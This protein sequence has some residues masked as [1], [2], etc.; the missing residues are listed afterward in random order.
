MIHYD[1]FYSMNNHAVE[2]NSSSRSPYFVEV[3]PMTPFTTNVNIANVIK[4]WRFSEVSGIKEN[5]RYAL[6]TGIIS[7]LSFLT[8]PAITAESVVFREPRLLWLAAVALIIGAVNGYLSLGTAHVAE[9]QYLNENQAG[10]SSQ[11]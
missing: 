4:A 2:T 9:I 3:T 6:A 1:I 7:I 5:A 11:G 10:N 8:A